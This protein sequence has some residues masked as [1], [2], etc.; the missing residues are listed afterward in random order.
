M[1][2][3]AVDPLHM[4]DPLMR[5]SEDGAAAEPSVDRRLA[6]RLAGEILTVA[7]SSAGGEPVPPGESVHSHQRDGDRWC[8]AQ[9]DEAAAPVE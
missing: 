7:G 6:I 9:P 2:L 4:T 5:P 1:T 3:T 8:Q